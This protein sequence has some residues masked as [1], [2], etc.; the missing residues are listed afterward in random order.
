[1]GKSSIS[2]DW[3]Q[4]A[5]ASMDGMG[6]LKGTEYADANDVLADIHG[7]DTSGELVGQE[8][9]A[10]YTPADQDL[11]AGELLARV[12]TEGD[13]RGRALGHRRNGD[14]VPL[15]LSLC[16]TNDGIVCVV[17]ERPE[18]T[19]SRRP[20]HNT[21]DQTHGNLH[22]P[23]GPVGLSETLLDTLDDVVY[24]VDEE[25][26][27]VGW[28][29]RLNERLGYTDEEVATMSLPDFLPEE[30]AELLGEAGT[31]MV[32][33]PDRVREMEVVSKDGGR[34][35]FE[36]R[37]VTYTD[38]DTGKR[39]RVG[40]ARDI[41]E[42]KARERE[43]ERY[44]TI[45]ET[46]D[47][48]VYVLDEDLRIEM[49]NER[50]FD[51]MAQFGFSRE[52]VRELHAHQLVVNEDERAVLE[53][54]IERAIERDSHIGS[55]EMSAD[56]P[57]GEKVVCESRFR[58]YPEPEGE[59][60]GCIGVL[61]DITE[62]K[63]Q[64]RRLTRQ[65]DELDTLNRINELLLAVARD[66]FESPM[67]GD[68]E[69]T[70]CSRLA[71]SDLYQF[72]WVGRPEAGGTQLAPHT[73]AGIDE[74]V[75]DSLTS[76]T[77]ED[78][79]GESLGGRAFRT[80]TIQVSQDIE[81]DPS[82]R[83][84][85][86]AATVE[87]VHS[88]AAVPLI[89]DG[90]TYGILAVYASRP[91][92]FSHR[93]QRGFEI[94]GEAIGYAINASKTR[95]L[96][97]AE[98]VVELELTLTN[99]RTFLVSTSADLGCS[100]S[101]EGYVA[102]TAGDWLLYLTVNEAEADRFVEAAV[103]NNHVRTVKPLDGDDTSRLVGLTLE[104]SLLD[105]IAAVGGNL[106]A[107][108]LESGTGRLTVEVPQSTDVR[109]FLNQVRAIYPDVSLA[110]RTEHE[111]SVTADT[112]FSDDR[113]PALTDRQRQ[114]LEAAFR[115]GYFEWPRESSAEEVADL[116]GIAR[117]TLHAHLRKAERELLSTFFDAG[118]SSSGRPAGTGN[119]T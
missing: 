48:G 59:H 118:R 85:R 49:A 22:G 42:R 110:A 76:T 2:V 53:A 95:E 3:T 114:A 86:E 61:R 21:D 115:A 82:F 40:I 68:I 31:R 30:Y 27:V 38:E 97:F 35:P 54:E 64:E 112:W 69:Q 96:L 12:R 16:V 51:M 101:L 93:E 99:S 83:Q 56:L 113:G 28:N 32:D 26:D 1:M 15:E 77:D 50:F 117:P 20:H 87:D 29:H 100:L 79:P 107:A 116:L 103:R 71:G 17:R 89:Y 11:T 36:L 6:L 65:R 25:D 10:L 70:V 109:T 75:L 9:V 33:F 94:L 44:E 55:F 14:G 43:L 13:W 78:T 106:T 104:S 45:V 119:G 84:W 58:L 39:Y 66:L 41:T 72:A 88:A 81:T 47:D 105:A 19:R 8:W 102:T 23:L 18:A 24:I 52:E 57:D 74:D 67:H 60:R 46:V 62:R 80:G 34:I 4:V 5:A 63:E 98:Q 108:S 37:G 90:T 111:R 92:A 91:L 7:Y 73:S